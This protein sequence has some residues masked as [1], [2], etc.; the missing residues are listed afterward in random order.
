[1]LKKNNDIT[2]FSPNM[3]KIFK[4]CPRRFYYRYIEQIPSPFPDKEFQTGKKLH[5]I[6]SYYLSGANISKFEQVLTDKEKTLWE[7]LK[8]KEYLSYDVVEIEK[9]MSVRLDDFWV[10]GRIDAIVKNGSDY[11][12]LDYKT[13][14][15]DDNMTY[16][17]QTMIYL[18]MWDK[19][20]KDASSLTFVY[21]DLKNNKEVKT[22][23][24]KDLKKE[25]TDR[26]ISVCK[27]ICCFKPLKYQPKNNCS[28]EYKNICLI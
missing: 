1:M 21:I 20:C 10:G 14:G 6:A 3:I 5:A 17:F 9:T 8:K 26:I 4:D 15:V 22:V 23:F 19:I 12:I 11:Y 24:S 28:C 25:Y 16:D 18:I 13:G 7:L 27:E 2:I